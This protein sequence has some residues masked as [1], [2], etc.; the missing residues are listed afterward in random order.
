MKESAK[1]FDCLTDEYKARKDGE[2][3]IDFTVNGVDFT[4]TVSNGVMVLWFDDEGQTAELFSNERRDRLRLIKW[5]DRAIGEA[6]Q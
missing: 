2:A 5:L 3:I 4:L 6:I 1:L